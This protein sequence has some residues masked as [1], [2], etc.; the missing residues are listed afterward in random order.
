MAV[1]KKYGFEIEWADR[2]RVLLDESVDRTPHFETDG[3][4]E[5]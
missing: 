1:G 3:V 2:K 4:S 5:G